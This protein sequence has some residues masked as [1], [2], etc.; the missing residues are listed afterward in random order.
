MW[1]VR[2]VGAAC[3]AAGGAAGA[4]ALLAAGAGRAAGAHAAPLTAAAFSPDGT[5]L[6]TAAKD[7]YVMFAQ[8]HT[9]VVIVRL[10][11]TRP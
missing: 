4:G 3:A 7:G 6:A 1:N 11:M 5:A 9:Y 8:V 10:Y 2:A